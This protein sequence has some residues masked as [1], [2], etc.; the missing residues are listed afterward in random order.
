[1]NCPG[2]PARRNRGT[3]VGVRG[4]R[5]GVVGGSIGGCAAAIALGRLGCDVTVFERSSGALRDRG[6]GIAIPVDLRNELIEHD[7]LP[8]GYR[9]WPDDAT[10]D[11]IRRGGARRW[12]IADGSPA[13]RL[14]WEQPSGGAAVCNNWSVL[15]QGLRARV[16]DASYRDGSTVT[17]VAQDDAGVD[18]VLDDGTVEHFDV[19]FGADGYRSLVRSLVSPGSNPRDAGYILWRGNFPEAELSDRR[20]W[21]EVLATTS[22]PVVAFDGGHAVMYPIP[23]FDGL[24]D[25]LRVNWAIYAPRPP[26][27]QLDGPSSIPPGT[28]PQEVFVHLRRLREAVIPADLQ[29]LWA[30]STDIVSIQP[31]YDETVDRYVAGPLALIG[32]AATLARPHT[33][34]GATK[35]MRDARCLEQLAGEHD[36]WSSLLEAYDAHQAPAGRALVE[37]GRRIGRDHVEQTPPWTDMTPKDFEAWVDGTLSGQHLYFYGATDDAEA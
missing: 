18:V 32:D 4:S 35:A 20:A 28:V 23:D 8:A 1:M 6:S 27:L 36:K 24:G 7:Y 15:W 14:L 30:G 22:T 31:I 2:I 37:L 19:V 11:D 10:P 25:G 13:G 3:V 12:V 29:P 33:G 34:S 5:V 16:P 17:A 21:D 9:C 26:E